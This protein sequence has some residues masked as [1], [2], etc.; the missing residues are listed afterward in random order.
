MSRW[1]PRRGSWKLGQLIKAYLEGNEGPV[2][3]EAM[4]KHL[5]TLG[6]YGP[7][8]ERILAQFVEVDEAGHVCLRGRSKGGGI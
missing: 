1:D 3:M 6:F 8:T 5:K 2:T 7:S 4:L